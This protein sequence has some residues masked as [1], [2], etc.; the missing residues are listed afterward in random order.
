MSIPSQISMNELLQSVEN[1]PFKELEQF[2]QQVLAL[3]AQR[4]TN[5]LSAQES[6]LLESI[7]QPISTLLQQRYNQLNKQQRQ[8]NLSED[9][10]KELLNLIEQI[11]KFDLQ[12]LRY[13]IKLAKLRKV[14]LDIIM[15]DLGIKAANYV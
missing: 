7:N 3:R 15:Q 2:I 8:N 12:R 14:S 6:E 4:S 13:L 10:H 5:S 9:E 1:L 11:E